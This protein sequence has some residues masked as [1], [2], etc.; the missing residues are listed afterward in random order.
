[1]IR[2]LKSG[3]QAIDKILKKEYSDQA[4]YEERV[5]EILQNVRDRGDAALLEYTARF[6]NARL[7]SETLRVS[8]EEIEAAYR[9]VDQ[10]FVK[11]IQVARD[12]IRSFHSKHSSG[13]NREAAGAGWYLCPGGDSQLSV[14]SIDECCACTGSGS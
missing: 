13:A 1:L 14:I 3:D 10:D 11:A 4:V 9:E 7:T 12:N 5:S 2:L 8:Q 6:D